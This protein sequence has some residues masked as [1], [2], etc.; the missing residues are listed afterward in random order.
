MNFYQSI[1]K[2]DK[3]MHVTLNLTMKQVHTKIK[4]VQYNLV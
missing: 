1:K 2:K 4:M 3:K